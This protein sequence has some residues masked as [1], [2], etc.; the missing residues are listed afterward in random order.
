MSVDP[1][2]YQ[3]VALRQAPS[4]W[5]IGEPNPVDL[6]GLAEPVPHLGLTSTPESSCAIIP[7]HSTAR[8]P[9]IM[10]V[11]TFVLR[12]GAARVL[13]FAAEFCG[14]AEG[15]CRLGD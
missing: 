1:S 3:T 12:P 13:V 11:D 14:R 5:C 7:T 4:V 6:E 10:F 8:E 9:G 15:L 2:E